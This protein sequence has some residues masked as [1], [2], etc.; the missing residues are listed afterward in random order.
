M[1]LDLSSS[2]QS[3]SFKLRFSRTASLFD[4]SSAVVAGP[5]T[6]PGLTII[7]H[8]L[9]YWVDLRN[10]GHIV[11]GI[12]ATVLLNYDTGSADT[13]VFGKFTLQNPSSSEKLIF[14]D[15]KGKGRNC[16][17]WKRM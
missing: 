10:A 4:S 5:A 11:V 13:F 17:I 12:G 7:T 14:C 8:W 16:S 6:I 1:D 2:D 15:S 9:P 3:V